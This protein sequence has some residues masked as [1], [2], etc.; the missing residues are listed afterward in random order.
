MF[1][2]KNLRLLELSTG[3][4]YF[5]KGMFDSYNNVE[6]FKREDIHEDNPWI[7]VPGDNI[8][9]E[10]LD[11]G[12]VNMID[13]KYAH[14]V[15]RPEITDLKINE[16][17]LEEI[18]NHFKVVFFYNSRRIYINNDVCDMVFGMTER[19]WSFSLEEES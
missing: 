13:P 3:G 16:D 1:I 6:I 17:K 2:T 19:S 14:L 15:A 12:L 9:Y 8:L 11:K 7:H 10:L 18:E 4:T 5:L